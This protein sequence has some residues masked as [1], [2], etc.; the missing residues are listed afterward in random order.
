MQA[1]KK[2][3][4][5]S[6]KERLVTSIR[7]FIELLEEQNEHEATADLSCAVADI[8]KYA[9]GSHEFKVWSQ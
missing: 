8:E 9:L 2:R 1:V 3:S 5:K 4:A 7:R 6:S